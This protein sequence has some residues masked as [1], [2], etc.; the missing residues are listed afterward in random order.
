MDLVLGLLPFEAWKQASNADWRRSGTRRD[1]RMRMAG[2]SLQRSSATGRNMPR[3]G[4]CA[5]LPLRR[6]QSPI[7]SSGA[8]LY[9][10][11]VPTTRGASPSNACGI[12]NI[13]GFCVTARC[14]GPRRPIKLGHTRISGTEAQPPR[15]HWPPAVACVRP[16]DFSS[17]NYGVS[18]PRRCRGRAAPYVRLFPDQVRGTARRGAGS[19]FPLAGAPSPPQR[20]TVASVI[21][22]SPSSP[23]SSLLSVIKSTLS[24]RSLQAT[25]TGRKAPEPSSSRAGVR[26]YSWEAV[27]RQR[28]NRLTVSGVPSQGDRQGAS[29]RS[30]HGAYR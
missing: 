27:V 11:S 4:L 12:I 26:R 20:V 7:G 13:K 30:R 28:P 5:R 24:G 22:L 21:G 15:A 29:Q 10:A 19:L 1:R 25:P 9:L 17:Q 23:L 14:R 8:W 16:E 3:T 2:R 18:L 6:I